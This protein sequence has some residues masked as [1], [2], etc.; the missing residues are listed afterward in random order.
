MTLLHERS[1]PGV[2]TTGQAHPPPTGTWTIDPADSSVWFARRRLRLWT[3]TGRLHSVGVIHLDELPP[4]GVIRFQQPSGLP[5]LTIALDPASIQTQQRLLADSD[6]GAV[7]SSGGG[8][9]AAR[10]WRSCPAASGESWP[11]S[12]PTAP[13]GLVELHLEIE[14]VPSDPDWL[15]LRGGGVLDRAAFAGKRASNLGPQ[16]RLELAVRA[17]KLSRS[18]W[19]LTPQPRAYRHRAGARMD[20]VLDAAAGPVWAVVY[21]VSA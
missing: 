15:V 1:Q 12:P 9:C 18:P 16:I 20:I 5:V 21:G 4:V 10:A 11:P 6:V 7:S 3:I 8:R 2:T 19:R 13:Q 14:P 17:R